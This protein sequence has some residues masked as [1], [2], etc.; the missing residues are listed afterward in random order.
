MKSKH[1]A[2]TV[3]A[4]IEVSYKPLIRISLLPEINCS[5]DVY[6]LFL[7]TWDKTKIEYVEHFKV[8]LMNRANR[9]LGI[10]TLTT[11]GVTGC[12]A[13]PRMVFGLALKTNACSLIIAHNHP[14][15]NI[16]PS[17]ADEELS[18]KMREAGK[19][20]DIKVLD[21]IILTTEGYYSFA[22]EGAM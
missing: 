19:L 22:D 20:L 5:K 8:M 21:H 12:I 9:V 17:R 1:D 15:G 3:I 14:S 10:C 2:T 11:G 18:Y 13:D 4:E 7:Q 16:K 6:E